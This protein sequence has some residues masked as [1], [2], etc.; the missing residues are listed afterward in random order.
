MTEA[1]ELAHIGNQSR[2]TFLKQPDSLFHLAG[3]LLPSIFAK[4][5][6]CL[7]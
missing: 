7:L 6:K 3:T 2:L 5:L 4:P 1:T